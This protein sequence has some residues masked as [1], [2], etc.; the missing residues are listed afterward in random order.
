MTSSN[1]KTPRAKVAPVKI[2]EHEIQG[3]M[4]HEG[5]FFVAASQVAEF[6][7]FAKT[8]ATREV[9]SLLGEDFQLFK[10]VSELNPKA[11]NV[12][13]LEALNL[14]TKRLA[15][16]GNQKA[17]AVDDALGLNS[18]AE[19]FC[20]A[21]DIETGKA[22]RS[23]RI[24]D[25]IKSVAC[26]DELTDSIKAYCRRHPELSENERKWM[27]KN[28]TDRLYAVLTGIRACDLRRVHGMEPGANVREWLRSTNQRK[29]VM[30]VSAMETS[31]AMLIDDDAH[32]D[33]VIEAVASVHAGRLSYLCQPLAA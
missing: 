26:R 29:A 24:A 17:V 7:Q 23:R 12:I 16:K 21:F 1:S 22:E 25:R 10:L 28:A 2:G 15:R 8:N 5:N 31:A 14:V 9:K 13:N 3:L 32:P 11:V 18:W 19:L 30:L 33:N 4:D 6:F 27:Y 20:D